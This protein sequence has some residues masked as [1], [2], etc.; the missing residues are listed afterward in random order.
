MADAM[1]MDGEEIIYKTEKHWLAP[2]ADSWKG[3]LLIIG[4]IA[5]SWLQPDASAG[6]MGFISRVLDLFKL[7]F[8]LVGIG[9]I[10]YSVI[11][12]RTAEYSVTNLRVLGHDGL[13]RSRSTDT[14]LTSISDVRTRV[15]GFGRMLG[16][17][18]DIRI[19]SASGEA[20]QDTFTTVKDVETFKKRILEQ[21]IAAESAKA[22][23]ATVAPAAAP[24]APAAADPMATLASLGQLRDQGVISAEEFEAKKQELLGRI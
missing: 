18:G 13:I 2:I 15:S 22:G 7:G 19:L 5:L 24:A 4:A 8:F 6:V 21:K 20:G 10:V 16:G 12:W 3:A 14:L 23:M 17:Y 9:W 1:L 11:A